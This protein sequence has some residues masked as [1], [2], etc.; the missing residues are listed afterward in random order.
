MNRRFYLISRAKKFPNQFSVHFLINHIIAEVNLLRFLV[1][2]VNLFSI[3]EIWTQL[4]LQYN[5]ALV[6]CY[7]LNIT[8]DFLDL[9]L[10]DLDFGRSRWSL[11]TLCERRLSFWRGF[12]MSDLSQSLWTHELA[13]SEPSLCSSWKQ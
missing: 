1:K 6:I 9:L 4:L 3:P 2:Y 10:L 8:F 7:L 5:I 12:S 13:L 11:S